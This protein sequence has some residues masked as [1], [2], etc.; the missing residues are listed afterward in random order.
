MPSTYAQ[1]LIRKLFTLGMGCIAR[2]RRSRGGPGSDS[3]DD[4]VMVARSAGAAVFHSACAWISE[5]EV[6]EETFSE[7]GGFCCHR[8]QVV[9]MPRLQDIAVLFLSCHGEKLRSRTGSGRLIFC[10]CVLH[11]LELVSSHSGRSVLG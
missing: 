1:V 5:E 8:V 10:L 2:R 11:A 6:V 9:I 7:G 3:G 4:G